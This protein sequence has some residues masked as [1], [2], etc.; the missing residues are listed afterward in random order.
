MFMNLAFFSSLANSCAHTCLN[1]DH[2]HLDMH[3]VVHIE[4][5][6]STPTRPPSSSLFPKSEEHTYKIGSEQIVLEICVPE[7]HGN[8]AVLIFK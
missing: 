4:K 6:F 5:F 8:I 3:I 1:T 7:Y 2:S